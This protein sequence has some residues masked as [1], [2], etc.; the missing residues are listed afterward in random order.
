MVAVVVTTVLVAVVAVAVALPLVALLDVDVCVWVVRALSGGTGTI[1]PSCLTETVVEVPEAPDASD[2][3]VACSEEDLTAV[4][5]PKPIASA[6]SSAAPSSNQ[7][8]RTDAERAA[9]T[10]P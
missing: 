5:T 7:R 9:F 3:A 1:V 10:S 8:R 2:P 6:A 4:P